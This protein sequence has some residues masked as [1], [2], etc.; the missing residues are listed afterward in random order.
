MSAVI[1]PSGTDR[2]LSLVDL[3]IA[4]PKRVLWAIAL[5]AMVFFAAFPFAKID[6]NPK[7]MLPP[8][9]A[10]R[11]SN[12]EVD[13]RF[14]LHE[15]TVVVAV[16]PAGGVLTQPSLKKLQAL[17][18]AILAMDG[19]VE[20]DVVSL[21]TTDNITSSQDSLR[22]RPLV[23]GHLDQPGAIQQLRTE[24]FDGTLFVDR[25]ISRDEKTTAIYVPLA[26]GA[27]ASAVA[28]RIGELASAQFS[29]EELA[30]TGDPVARDRFGGEMFKLMAVFAPM[31]GMLMMALVYGMFRSGWLAGVVMMAAMVAIGCAL[32]A[33]I[34]LGYPVHIMSS[35]APVFLMAI[36][37][38]GIHI[39]NEFFLRFKGGANRGEVIR[40]TMNAVARP[41]R[42]TLLATAAGFGVLLFMSIVPVKVFG[43]IIVAG[44]VVLRILSFTLM[45]AAL[46]LI[47]LSPKAVQAA[48]QGAQAQTGLERLLAALARGSIRHHK[49]LTLGAVA[50]L[51]ISVWGMSHIVVNNN[52]LHWFKPGSDLRQADALISRQLG[53]SAPAYLV[54][55]TGTADG[56]KDPK[57][58]AAMDRLQS[59]L[60]QKG[61][62]GNTLSVAD[63]VKRINR[64]LNGD[65]PE[66]EVL[67]DDAAA[68]G[69][70]LLAFS[71]A[72]KPSDLNRVADDGFERA[73]IILQLRSWDAQAMQRVMDHVEAFRQREK[74]G[75]AIHPAGSAYFNLVWNHE[76]LRDMIVGFGL[77]LVAVF[78][79]LA[80]DFRSIK[81]AVVAY[82]PLL[83]T[84]ATVFGVIGWVGKD[85]DMPVAVLSCLSLGM[86]VD[87]AI[88]FVTRLRQRL[89]MS[90]QADPNQRVNEA[91]TW[92][93]TWP[94]KG[95]IR[96]AALFAVAFSVM[97]LAP[98]TPYMT[99]GVFIVAMMALSSLATLSLLPALIKTF[100]LQ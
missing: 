24:L 4:H 49:A 28:E 39:F 19:V 82:I 33:A 16:S 68:V 59:E 27:D 80:L 90:T 43:A 18:Q 84:V 56:I 34:A 12:D 60:K 88:H 83:L 44:T 36:A 41:V 86:A 99:V 8:T 76:V 51:G 13:K 37:T 79:I 55:D 87:F 66:Q 47:P 61:L 91:L 81:W 30:I 45:P 11:I 14:G 32:G 57:V 29:S 75:F 9:A 10:V 85:F 40:D 38:D 20:R 31:A 78:A 97:V 64:V 77:A 23:P 58:L 2:S 74:L 69:Q 48:A 62:V 22:I 7:N 65:R 50:L 100:K 98:L 21:F 46:M 63:Y 95:I 26:K 42:Y 72:A 53:G 70:Y 73:N 15:D 5:L 92:V 94:G 6:T 89:D 96:N 1:R 67:P 52:L 71:M 35:M 54:V 93:I 25:L 17:N 3:S